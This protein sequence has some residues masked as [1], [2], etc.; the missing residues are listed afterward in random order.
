V[1]EP[2]I[3]THLSKGHQLVPFHSLR[4]TIGINICDFELFFDCPDPLRSFQ[5]FDTTYQTALVP[6]L[7]RL[8]FLQLPKPTLQGQ[9]RLGQWLS[10][11]KGELAEGG[12]GDVWG[13]G[14]SVR[15]RDLTKV[16]SERC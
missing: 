3:E 1:P 16:G 9:R 2:L 11:F 6:E 12:D 4:S 15:L 8:V 7:L 5:L 14:R 10:F 13:P